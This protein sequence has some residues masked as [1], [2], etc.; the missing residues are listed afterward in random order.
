MNAA[1]NEGELDEASLVKF[2]MDL[3]GTSESCARSVYMF[4]SREEEQK[5]KLNGLDKWRPKKTESQSTLA[6]TSRAQAES[7]PNL[8]I[9]LLATQ[10]MPVTAK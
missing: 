7:E 4:I 3:T 9:G 10:G 1:A 5:A 8:G 2:Y 6:Q